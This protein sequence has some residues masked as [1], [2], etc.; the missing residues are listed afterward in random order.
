EPVESV[1]FR[2]LQVDEE[3]FAALKDAIADDL[4]LFN[5]DNVSEVLSKYLGSSIRVTDTDD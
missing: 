1:L 5:A 2:E 3:Y 4:D